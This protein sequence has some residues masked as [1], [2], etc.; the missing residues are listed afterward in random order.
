MYTRVVRLGSG[1]FEI[2]AAFHT[3]RSFS[4]LDSSQHDGPQGRYSVLAWEPESTFRVKG[5]DP[6]PRLKQALA[7]PDG[8]SAIGYFSYDLFRFLEQ[9]DRLKSVDDLGLPDCCLSTYDVTLYFDHESGLWTFEGTSEQAVERRLAE[10]RLTEGHST[11]VGN[12]CRTGPLKSNMTKG[13]YVDR[14]GKALEYIA[15][16]DIYQV[17]VAQRFRHRFEGS[18]FRVFANLRTAN[19]SYYGAYLNCGDHVVISSSPELFLHR[20]GRAIETR[21]IKGTRPRGRNAAEDAALERDL[22]ANDKEAAELTMIV[23]LERNDLGRVCEYGSVEV[24]NHRYVERLPTLFH[25]VSTVRGRLRENTG[26]V[27]I[28]RALFPGGSISGCP[29]VRAIEIIDE[30]EP[31][32]RHVYTGAIG[33]IRPSG[34]MTLN[35]AIRTMTVLK[36]SVCYHA[37]SGIVADSIPDREYEETLQK[38]A[39]IQAAL[40]F[41]G[42]AISESETD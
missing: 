16:G 21:P 38:A 14:V 30:L 37:G 33:L 27:E 13:D 26:P 42:L 31:V 29:K 41:S 9:Y 6:F 35:I 23:D 8:M 32:R 2:A 3:R 17:N 15:A 24:I 10:V 20:E 22:K 4:F 7:I 5:E 19:P 18:A 28:L 11:D 39:A 25:T 36:D 12:E 34:D 1:P 40:G